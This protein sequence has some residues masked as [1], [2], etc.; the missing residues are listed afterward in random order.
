[1]DRVAI[2]V[3][4]SFRTERTPEEEISFRHLVRCLGRYDRYV[5][6]PEGTSVAWSGFEVEAFPREYFGS[7]QAHTRLLFSRRFYERFSRYEY[8]L[9]YHL[10]CLV[11]DDQ[12]EAWCSRGLDYIG[13]PW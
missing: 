5:V 3:P 4:L 11:F 2:M 1:M 8:L 6:V 9:T 10:D 7:A 12:L 13:A